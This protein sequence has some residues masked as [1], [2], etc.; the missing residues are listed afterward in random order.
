MNSE[1]STQY[2]HPHYLVNEENFKDA[3]EFWESFFSAIAREL[4][5][6]DLWFTFGSTSANLGYGESWHPIYIA[7]EF[8]GISPILRKVRKNPNKIIML[9]VMDGRQLTDPEKDS[10]EGIIDVSVDIG[11]WDTGY[12]DGEST[13]LKIWTL[14]TTENIQKIRK[15]IREWMRDSTDIDGMRRY[16]LINKLKA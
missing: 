14:P 16:I 3:E 11:F 1:L 2:V 13:E 9:T 6:E 15:C 7:E 5:A 8:G 10:Q 4:D 12:T